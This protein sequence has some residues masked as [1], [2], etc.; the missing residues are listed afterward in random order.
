MAGTIVRA[1]VAEITPEIIAQEALTV[2]AA[3]LHLARNVTKESD[4][5]DRSKLGAVAMGDVVNVPITGALVANQKSQGGEVSVQDPSMDKVQISIDQHWEVTIAPEDYAQAT[6][7]RNIQDTYLGDMIRALAEQI[8]TKLATVAQGFSTHAA[9]DATSGIDEDD[10]LEIRKRLTQ[11][12]APMSDRFVYLDS[13]A[14]NSTLKIDRF[15]AVEKY[16]ANTIIQ[17]GELGK[18]HGSR[19]LESIFVPDDGGSPATYNN[20][21]MHKRALVLC[22]RPLPTPR[23]GG[24]K[25]SVIVDPVSGLAMRVL[26]SYNANKLADQVTLDVLFG[27][28]ILR[29]ELGMIV[30]TR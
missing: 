17:D 13:G 20:I 29:D 30:H 8:E 2:L 24:V 23:G 5:V 7:D 1:D 12:R 6:A 26:Y 25:A 18:I 21:A 3:E 16:G 19:V 10:Y 15:T 4:I 9:I 27:A 28:G 11:S 14:V 22:M